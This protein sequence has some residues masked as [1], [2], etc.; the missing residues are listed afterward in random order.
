MPYAYFPGCTLGGSAQEYDT[1]FRWVCRFLGIK[2]QEVRDWVCCGACSARATSH[3]LSVSM[4]AI[5]LSHAEQDGF[6]QMIAPCLI[7]SSRMKAANLAIQ[8]DEDLRR[9]VNE[10]LEESYKG[11]VKVVHP[12]EVL[13]NDIGLDAL[14]EKVKKRLRGLRVACYYGCT[15]TRPPAV[16]QFDNTE[17][18]MSMD[19]ILR[20]VGLETVDWVYKTECC[21]VNMTVT[22]ADMVVHLGHLILRAAREVKADMIAVCCP[23]CHANLDMRQNQIAEKYGERFDIPVLYFT[24]LL[25]IIYGA[26]S[27]ELGL[28]RLMVSAQR[29]LEE[30][31]IL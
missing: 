30:Y 4:P 23:I 29:A 6:D 18:P 16:S 8:R 24:Q 5:S 13:L 1:S 31:G 20:A 12:L 14:G 10:V 2:L 9:K 7:G 26:Y 17:Y 21:G 11:T 3:L 28:K 15:L 22:R 27:G 19:N 25:G